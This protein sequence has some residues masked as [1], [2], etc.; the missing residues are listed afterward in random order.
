MKKR[1]IPPLSLLLSLLFVFT[2]CTGS[3]ETETVTDTEPS[4]A[5][6]RE[7][8]TEPV[9]ET[10]EETTGAPEPPPYDDTHAYIFASNDKKTKWVSRGAEISREF[11]V[12]KMIPTDHDPMIYCTFDESERFDSQE[13]PYVAYRYSV[14]SSLR[15]GVFFVGSEDHPDFSDS[16]LTW[17]DVKNNGE[18]TDN[19]TDMRGNNFWEGTIT[20]FRVDPINGGTHDKKAVILLDRIG[21]FKTEQDARDFLSCAKEPDYSESVSFSKGFAKAV[22]P[23][24]TLKAG[25]DSSDYLLKLDSPAE[26]KNGI[27]PLVAVT[28]DGV[29]KIVPVQ[30]VNS[31]GFVS[32]LAGQAGEYSLVYP[33]KAAVTDADFVISRGIMTEED[34]AA[35]SFSV[36]RIGEILFNVLGKPGVPAPDFSRA[37]NTEDVAVLISNYLRLLNITPYTDPALEIK[38]REDLNLAVCSGIV[39]DLSPGAVTGEELASILVR[40]VKAVLGQPVLPSNIKEN[41]GMVIGAW[42]NF[43]FDVTDEAIKTFAD[44]GLSLLIDLGSIEQRGV[45]DTVMQSAGKYGV[46]VLRT[47]YSPSLFK[48]SDPDPIPSLCYEY[49]D[50]DSYYGNLIFDEP[51]TDRFSM[52]ADIAAYYDKVMPGKLCY[53]NLLPMY[54]NAA[55]LKY[56]AGAARIDYYDPDPDLYKK[57]ISAYAETV[58]GDFMCVD[59]YPY[60]SNGSKKSV[61]T[62]YLKNMAIFADACRKYDRDFWLFIQSTDY[63]GGKWAPDYSDI[64]WQLYIGASFGVKT[65]LHYLY[66]Y[67]NHHALVDAGETTEIYDAAKKANFE[68]LAFS[69]DYGR[70]ENVGAFNVNCEK[71]KYRYAQFDGQYDGLT[72]LK[73]IQSSDP[74]LFGCFREKNGDGYAFTVVNMAEP[75]KTKNAAEVSF[76]L[77]NANSVHVWASGEK[78]ELTPEDGV[79]TLSLDNAEGVFIT[80]D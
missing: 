34:V 24:G 80:V 57:Y 58:P 10:G 5:T 72:G 42:S 73:D 12:L 61:Y 63:D 20:S 13:Y 40:F 26:I 48:A 6:D 55:Q 31:V 37:A 11:N 17:I 32:Y 21:F 60:R 66:N 16:G 27:S 4:T 7:T 53:Y 49:Y 18:W 14:K 50:F 29:Q 77:D 23:G 76:R 38:G 1:M 67:N 36:F 52:M 70:Y 45:I 33:D 59:I 78:S 41:A 2:A 65:F 79:Y 46:R 64:R 25:Y 51:G 30:Y 35:S 56:G 47:N 22:V 43:N 3:V 62:E 71:T 19:I 8:D 69:D 15:Q 75:G 9:T 68:L 39:T 28:V 74:L 44:A 54:A